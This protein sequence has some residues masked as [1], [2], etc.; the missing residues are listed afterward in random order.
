M[1][2]APTH[3]TLIVANRTAGT[4][5]LLEEVKRRAVREPT[6]FVLLIPG[7]SWTRSNRFRRPSPAAGSTTS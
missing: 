6:A 4:P 7:I 3:R 2:T 1:A 5:L